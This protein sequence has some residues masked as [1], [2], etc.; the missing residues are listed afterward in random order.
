MLEQRVLVRN[1]NDNL[2]SNLYFLYKGHHD[3]NISFNQNTEE[4]KKSVGS[5]EHYI[6][7]SDNASE[8]IS[9]HSNNSRERESI[10]TELR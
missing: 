2:L 6:L 10:K 3:Q 1:L 5:D 8:A 7:R 4:S 9:I